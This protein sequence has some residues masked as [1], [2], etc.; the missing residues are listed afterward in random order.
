[1]LRIQ[2]LISTHENLIQTK[3][4]IPRSEPFRIDASASDMLRAEHIQI[5]LRSSCFMLQMQYQ[6]YRT[7]LIY[8]KLQEECRGRYTLHMTRHDTRWLKYRLMGKSYRLYIP[9][10]HDTT[11]H[12]TTFW[13]R[14]ISSFFFVL[15]R[16]VPCRVQCIKAF[17]DIYRFNNIDLSITSHDTFRISLLT[18]PQASSMLN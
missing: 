2:Y 3:L 18:G 6:K 1:M 7:P 13:N 10:W 8:A 16:I 15:C 9:Q 12:N 4:L 5:F 17:T 11:R 14:I